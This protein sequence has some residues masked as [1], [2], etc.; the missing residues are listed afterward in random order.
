MTPIEFSLPLPPNKNTRNTI[1]YGRHMAAMKNVWKYRGEVKLLLS[2]YKGHFKKGEKLVVACVWKL[3]SLRMDCHNFHQ[4]LA[5]A[6]AP[7][8]DLNDKWFLIRDMDF[9]VETP[10]RVDVQMWR[11]GDVLK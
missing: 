5:D 1:G 4:E 9:V 11:T 7:A 6:I 3:P 2:K 8:M 10:S